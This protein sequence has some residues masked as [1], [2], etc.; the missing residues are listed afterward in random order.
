[1]KQISN[2]KIEHDLRK[3]D[4]AITLILE[5]L[6]DE[7]VQTAIQYSMDDIDFEIVTGTVKVYPKEEVK[8]ND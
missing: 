7:R 6:K 3:Q 4:D 8:E 1:M 5:S 2:F